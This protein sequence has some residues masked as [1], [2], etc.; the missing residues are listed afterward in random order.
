MKAARW[1]PFPY[2]IPK[3]KII[4]VAFYAE[5]FPNPDHARLTPRRHEK[6]IVRAIG[7]DIASQ[8]KLKRYCFKNFTIFFELNILT[9]LI[10]N[11]P[12]NHPHLSASRRRPYSCSRKNL[13]RNS[14]IHP[15]TC[16][17]TLYKQALRPPR[18]QRQ[19]LQLP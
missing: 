11:R 3:L 18:H 12:R 2:K 16:H 8:S 19:L 5:S 17:N 7:Q 1:Q 4:V 14:S 10:S 13:P 15:E 9:P 6:V